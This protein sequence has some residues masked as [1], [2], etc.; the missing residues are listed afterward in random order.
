M[1]HIS[2]ELLNISGN[3]NMM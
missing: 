2:W 1:R 3:F